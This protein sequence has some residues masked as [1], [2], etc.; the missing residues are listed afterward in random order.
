M[1]RVNKYQNFSAWL[2]KRIKANRFNFLKNIDIKN[3]PAHKYLEY[4]GKLYW[5]LHID[6]PEGQDYGILYV[7]LVGFVRKLQKGPSTDI[8]PVNDQQIKIQ[9]SHEIRRKKKDN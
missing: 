8:I 9:V 4:K 5:P 2:Q 3:W 7:K 1:P 6:W